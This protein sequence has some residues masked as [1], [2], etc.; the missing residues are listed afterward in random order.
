MFKNNSL[1]SNL[2]MHMY[3]QKSK[4][5]FSNLMGL[6]T[7]L[8]LFSLSYISKNKSHNLIIKRKK[9]KS[10]SQQLVELN[11]FSYGIIFDL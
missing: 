2:Y 9:E 4:L 11:G 8:N 1:V 5:A 6:T 7:K 10:G 3:Y